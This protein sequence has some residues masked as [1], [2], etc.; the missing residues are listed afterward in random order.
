[1][2][3]DY[4]VR[5]EPEEEGMTWQDRE[6]YEKLSAPA[7]LAVNDSAM[8]DE[9]EE[10]TLADEC[11]RFPWG[12]P[13][14]NSEITSERFSESKILELDY[15]DGSPSIIARMAKEVSRTVQFPG[16][17]AYLHGLGV[18][19]SSAVVNFEVEYYGATIPV[20]LYTICAQPSG[21]GKSGAHSIFIN[22]VHAAMDRRNSYLFLRHRNID[23]E[24][25]AL[26]K[27]ASDA[28]DDAAVRLVAKQIDALKRDKYRAPLVHAAKKNTTPEA[29]E[30]AAGQQGG[31]LN[32]CSDE[33]EA[34]DTYLGISYRD[35]KK[36]KSN[37][38]MFIACFDGGEISTA[39][40]GR[41][42]YSGRVRG[43]FAVIAQA[44]VI[45]TLIDEGS[46]GRGVNE[47]VLMLKERTLI[48]YRTHSIDR[49]EFNPELKA[50]YDRLVERVLDGEYPRTLKL[51]RDA[52]EMLIDLKND[53]E[54]QERP[55]AKYGGDQIRGF[56]SKMEQHITKVAG[57]L[58]IA[59]QFG[60]RNHEKPSMVI[61]SETMH[62]AI[63]VCM[64]LLESYRVLVE[65]YTAAGGAKPIIEVMGALKH[66]VANKGLTHVSINKMRLYFSKHDW[67][68]GVEKKTEF[69][70]N[71]L[72]RCETMNICH[73]KEIG[74]NKA[75]WV[76]LLNPQLANF[77]IQG[78]AE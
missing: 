64:D 12:A 17:T 36:A 42:G 71:I 76:A 54:V 61:D 34:I 38:G 22:P 40:V 55:G 45:D 70:A 16:N 32:V 63:L 19:S 11:G 18:F 60:D 68:K 46:L 47:R 48:G 28:S 77:T 50:E 69:L 75:K 23:K 67:F 72:A 52:L 31:V 20:G 41:V 3:A 6:E 15:L 14:A 2:K 57:L 4:V 25:E 33:A 78:D 53:I 39:R 58:H 44:S 65:S 27:R 9:I 7:E 51:S 8:E 73:V 49:E 43:A 26:D 13:F 5:L 30:E 1:M 29:A 10:L 21:S 37:N 56:A 35:S 74:A 62:K 66:Y 59:E 24:M